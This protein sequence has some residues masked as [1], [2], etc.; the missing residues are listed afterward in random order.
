LASAVTTLESASACAS[1]T[2]IN[3]TR[4]ESTYDFD[5]HV[6]VL[7]TPS[8]KSGPVKA[9]PVQN[10]QKEPYVKKIRESDPLRQYRFDNKLSDSWDLSDLSYDQFSGPLPTFT[11]DG[12][13]YDF[14]RIMNTGERVVRIRVKEDPDF[15][16]SKDSDDESCVGVST[17]AS[18]LKHPFIIGRTVS[19]FD[20]PITPL[21]VT[22]LYN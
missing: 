12:K 14:G 3:N 9:F 4:R 5:K 17:P 11:K 1:T 13:V 10:S 7:D 22:I 6:S 21:I 20:M 19:N 8:V 18:L 2:V 15:D 16:F